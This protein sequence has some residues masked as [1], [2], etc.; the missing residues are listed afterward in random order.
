[1]KQTY[2]LINRL[3]ENPNTKL[4][5]VVYNDDMIEPAKILIAQL[6]GPDYVKNVN[7]VSVGSQIDKFSKVYLDPQLHNYLGNGNV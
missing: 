4:T 1:M 6:R 3:P 7:V 2:D 5:W